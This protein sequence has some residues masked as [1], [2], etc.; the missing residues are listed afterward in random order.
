LI[1]KKEKIE[2]EIGSAKIE[3]GICGLKN[4]RI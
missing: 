1:K 3:E 2:K 4:E